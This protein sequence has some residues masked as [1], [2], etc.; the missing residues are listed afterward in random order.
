MDMIKMLAELRQ[1]RDQL[2]E[3]ILTLERL[4]SRRGQRRG[5]PAVRMTGLKRRGRPPGG[6]NKNKRRFESMK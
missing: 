3:A 5:Q 2:A 4:S 6:K 1:E